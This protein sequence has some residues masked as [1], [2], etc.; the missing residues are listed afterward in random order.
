M[1]RAYAQDA[2]QWYTRV[3]IRRTRLEI[4]EALDEFGVSDYGWRNDA[5]TFEIGG[6]EYRIKP[7]PLPV[8]TANPKGPTAAQVEKAERQAWRIMRDYVIGVI[9]MAWFVE[10]EQAFLQFLVLPGGQTLG[11]IQADVIA[12]NSLPAPAD[13]HDDD[14]IDAE[15]TAS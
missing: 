13:H 12:G 8:R 14:T 15:F 9:K 6:N 10:A 1:P 3:S 4:I 11:E 2:P 7:H 5:L